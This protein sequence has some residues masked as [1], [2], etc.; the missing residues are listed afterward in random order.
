MIQ[1]EKIREK[2]S[3]NRELLREIEEVR[4]LAAECESS[5]R[6]LSEKEIETLTTQGNRSRDWKALR[7]HPDFTPVAIFDSVFHG[8][9]RLGVFTGAPVSLNEE[10]ELPDGIYKSDIA[11]STVLNGALVQNTG[12]LNR[13]LVQ[14]KAVIINCGTISAPRNCAFG[15]AAEIHPGS[16]AG[17]REIPLY[18]EADIEVIEA[19][20][21]GHNEEISN[22][23]HSHCKEYLAAATFQGGIIGKEV[24]IS[25]TPKIYGSYIG[26]GCR[27][28]EA[29][30]IENS[31]LLS[32]ENQR[33]RVT[34]GAIVRQSALQWGAEAADGAIVDSSLLMEC[35]S[36][37]RHGKVTES[38]IGANTEIA[39]GEVT[40]SLLG[41]FTGFH[42]QSL[43]IAA[44]WARGRGN[45]GYGANVGSNHTGKA[46]DQEIICGEG[47]FF[48]LGSSIKFPA[49]YEKSPYTL[50]A[51]GVITL[52]QK[53]D[54]PF[55]LIN[56][57]SQRV[58]QVPQPY[59][60]LLPGWVLTQALYIVMR[61]RLKFRNR[62]RATRIIPDQEIFRYD[63]VT[64]VKEARD[65]LNNIRLKRE[66]Y[67][68]RDI[69][70]IGKNYMT[71]RCRK[72]AVYI[73]SL[74]IEFFI[75]V[76]LLDHIREI[77]EYNEN[78]LFETESDNNTWEE[79]RLL[80]LDEKWYPRNL[81]AS[82]KSLIDIAG[83]I[84]RNT[85]MSKERDDGRGKKIIPD[86]LKVTRRAEDEETVK[87]TTL[88]S[89]TII[90]EAEKIISRL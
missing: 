40:S 56:T 58:R 71:E 65:R 52:P 17:G 81:K 47:M 16:E 22:L 75:L 54:Y 72:S 15:I 19:V 84:A 11:E 43:L 88:W 42:H 20:I 46:P 83:K 73:Y 74:F 69:P 57:S 76:N 10:T 25:G 14:T 64:C 13:Y 32:D 33:T 28:E 38:V 48:G 51:T 90:A 5:W 67:L 9:C 89:D 1:P 87:D 45:V 62:N 26:T 79:A 31:V 12:L 86:Y 82:M 23:Y 7:V 3:W 37:R 85:K 35:A 80:M 66:I 60:E 30:L 44:L 41:A 4:H 53:V 70:G 29:T 34:S 68:E 24:K 55:S 63:L 49:N 36:A 6:P 77:D 18:P 78:L 50:I 39:E 21:R 2:L 27:V 61:N 59:N 8:S